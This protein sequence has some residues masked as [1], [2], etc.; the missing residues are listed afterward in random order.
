MNWL[1]CTGDKINNRKYF[2]LLDF[3]NEIKF[4][5]SLASAQFSDIYEYSL[6]CD[7]YLQS[8]VGFTSLHVSKKHMLGTITLKSVFYS[9]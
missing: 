3:L 1:L 7:K 4:V 2:V 9:L 6:S 5:K 8:L